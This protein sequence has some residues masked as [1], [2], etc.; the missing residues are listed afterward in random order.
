[1]GN[2]SVNPNTLNAKTLSRLNTCRTH[3]LMLSN[4]VLQLLYS[5]AINF[6]S[7]SLLQT[8]VRPGQP[9]NLGPLVT[10]PSDPTSLS[11]LTPVRRHT[12]PGI[13]STGPLVSP[14]K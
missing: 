4:S 8:V 14:S 9:R 10:V 11:K 3:R 13:A 7:F 12:R 1:M 6:I 5:V 2:V